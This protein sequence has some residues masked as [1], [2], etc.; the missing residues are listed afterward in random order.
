[1]DYLPAFPATPEEF[2]EYCA[3]LQEIARS[4]EG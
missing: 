2:E 3:V 4:L 1:M